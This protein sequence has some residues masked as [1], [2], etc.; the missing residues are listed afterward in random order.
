MCIRDSHEGVVIDTNWRET[1]IRD[2]Y[3]N[4]IIIPNTMTASEKITNFSLPDEKTALLFPVKVGYDSSPSDVFDALENAAGDVSEVLKNPAP[5]VHLNGYDDLGIS[6]RLKFWITDFKRKNSIMAEIGRKIWYRF[7]RNNIEIPLPIGDKLK[8][9]LFSVDRT[10]GTE[11]MKRDV[12]KNYEDLM[13][14]SFLKLLDGKGREKLLVSESEQSELAQ[15]VDRHRFT[16]GEVI[17]RQGDKGESCFV[18]AKG[19]IRGEIEYQEKRKKH[20]NEFEIKPGGIFG[21]MSLFTGM[22][23]TATGIVMEEAELLEINKD[24]FASLLDKNP[25]LADAVA[26]I[27]S[28]RNQENREFLKKIKELS[29]E[30][31][32]NSVNK[33]TILKFLTGLLGARRKTHVS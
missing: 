30:D 4:I 22:P 17:F 19:K 23:R 13:A 2:R 24:A 8:E 20:K 32:E 11:A 12:D 26:D 6:Y 16:P 15:R 10:S 9:V 33:K 31:I 7:Q 21:E 5:E 28:K 1:K 25:T 29:K 27:I 18:V 3:S 14:S